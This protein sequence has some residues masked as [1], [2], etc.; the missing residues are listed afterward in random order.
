MAL[1]IREDREGTQL[2][3]DIGME[4]TKDA[5]GN[6]YSSYSGILVEFWTLF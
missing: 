1:K 5:S 6:M 3:H 2:C 4:E